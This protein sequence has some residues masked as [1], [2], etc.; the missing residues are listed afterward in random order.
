MSAFKISRVA[1]CLRNVEIWQA[2]FLP[3]CLGV[4]DTELSWHLVRA[5]TTCADATAIDAVTCSLIGASLGIGCV[6]TGTGLTGTCAPG[7]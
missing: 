1:A 2:T 6:F 5:A 4:H 7:A 3:T